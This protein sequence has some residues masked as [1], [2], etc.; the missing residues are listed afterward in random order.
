MLWQIRWYPAFNCWSLSSPRTRHVKKLKDF[1]K[2]HIIYA[3][4]FN[5]LYWKIYIVLLCSVFADWRNLQIWQ[6]LMD[7][8]NFIHP[9]C[10][11]LW[12]SCIFRLLGITLTWLVDRTA[13]TYMV[14]SF[15]ATACG[16]WQFP[17]YHVPQSCIRPTHLHLNF[18][19]HLHQEI[20]TILAGCLW[21]KLVWGCSGH[22]KSPDQIW[23][24]LHKD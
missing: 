5:A 1:F 20:F 6:M 17:T 3:M 10:V 24:M 21:A 23:M 8:L 7:L 13:Y 9:N 15:F 18:S 11:F 16:S 4:Y 2:I 19:L 12:H 14:S 22:L